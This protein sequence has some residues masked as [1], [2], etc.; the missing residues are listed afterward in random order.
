MI[1][2]CMFGA[3]LTALAACGVD[4]EPAPPPDVRAGVTINS[5]GVYPSLG[6]GFDAGPLRVWVGG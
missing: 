4:G 1:R 5:S 3:A 6:V 2:F